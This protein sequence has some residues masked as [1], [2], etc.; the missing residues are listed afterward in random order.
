MHNGAEGEHFKVK[1]VVWHKSKA[2]FTSISYEDLKNTRLI[3]VDQHKRD[4]Q[5]QKA[6]GWWVK[7]KYAQQDSYATKGVNL[8]QPI[9]VWIIL[10]FFFTKKRSCVGISLNI[11]VGLWLGCL[12]WL[13]R[14][15]RRRSLR[16]G[17]ERRL[18]CWE[19]CCLWVP[20]VRHLWITTENK[21]IRI[22]NV[23]ISKELQNVKFKL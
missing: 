20:G 18:R 13:G 9:M 21:E 19:I 4:K 16:W 5:H 23:N 22:F 10:I 3:Q 12:C 2:K 17:H 11:F 7:P 8:V 14:L 15:L 6:A 1:K